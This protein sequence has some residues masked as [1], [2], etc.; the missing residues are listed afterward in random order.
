MK[1]IEVDYTIGNETKKLRIDFLSHGAGY[2]MMDNFFH[3]QAVFSQNQW[4]VYLNN[5]SELNNSADIQ[6]LIEIL[7]EMNKE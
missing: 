5:K 1:D 2:I 3:G 6:A 7:N 4:R